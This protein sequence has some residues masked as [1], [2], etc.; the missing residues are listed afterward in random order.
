M[1]RKEKEQLPNL[2]PEWRISIL[3]RL[4]VT[5]LGIIKPRAGERRRDEVSRDAGGVARRRSGYRPSNPMRRR[6]RER[7]SEIEA[8]AQ[9]D[10]IVGH[11]G[12]SIRGRRSSG[13]LSL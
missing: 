12:G 8:L 7:P 5:T 4:W 10:T 2:A 13:R 1:T 9:T 6:S 3:T 11:R